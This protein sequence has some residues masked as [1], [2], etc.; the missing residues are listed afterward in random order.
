MRAFSLVA[1]TAASRSTV[2]PHRG[3]PRSRTR[4]R[5]TL[6][7]VTTDCCPSTRSRHSGRDLLGVLERRPP[8]PRASRWPRLELVAGRFA[9]R[10]AGVEVVGEVLRARAHHARGASALRRADPRRAG[11]PSR[12]SP[13]RALPRAPRV[14]ARSSAVRTSVIRRRSACCASSSAVT[15]SDSASRRTRAARAS[16]ASA[17]SCRPRPRRPSRRCTTPSARTTVPSS[18]TSVHP[19]PSAR[20]PDRDLG[21]R[22]PPPR[23]RRARAPALVLGREPEP[24][25]ERPEHALA[26]RA[27]AAPRPPRTEA[28]PRSTRA[29]PRL[30]CARSASSA[31]PRST[32][33]TTTLCSRSPSRPAKAARQLGR[34]LDP[35]GHEPEQRRV[36]GLEEV[37]H[38]R[39][40]RPRAARAAPPARAAG[41]ACWLSS[42]LA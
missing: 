23:R 5:R 12:P 18:V 8:P 25:D 21:G 33:L 31:T 11:D 10:P 27:A 20:E 22:R 16:R 41:C 14:R 42:F 7:S 19:A 34:R 37:L 15:S 2:P 29:R 13:G 24:V 4:A 35:V 26:L 17:R 28:A 38:A 30:F 40:R 9:A 32:S 3:W 1:P 6:R 36:L 39:R